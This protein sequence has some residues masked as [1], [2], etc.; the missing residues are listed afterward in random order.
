M[1][2]HQDKYYRVKITEAKLYMRKKKVTDFGLSSIEKIVENIRNIQL[3]GS[4]INHSFGHSWCAKLAT[5][6]RFCQRASSS[7]DFVIEF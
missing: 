7:N 1:S 3:Y 5:R 4:F 6:T 2:E